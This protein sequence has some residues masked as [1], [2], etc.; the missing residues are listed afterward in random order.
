MSQQLAYGC[1]L[2]VVVFESVPLTADDAFRL[3]D[4]STLLWR[5]LFAHTCLDFCYIVILQET[6]VSDRAATQR[7]VSD[8]SERSEVWGGGL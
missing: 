5:W 2:F 1:L 4:G 7:A 8:S 6:I 3:M